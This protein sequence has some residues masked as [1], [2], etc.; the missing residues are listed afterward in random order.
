MAIGILDAEI[1]NELKPEKN[2]GVTMYPAFSLV[3][4]FSWADKAG[5]TIE[6]VEGVFYAPTSQTGQLAL[7]YVAERRDGDYEQFRQTC[8]RLASEIQA[9]AASR[10]M[11]GYFE[12][13]ISD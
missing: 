13:G 5:R 11:G 12:I 9:A 8:V 7:D 3:Q 1:S 6:W 10:E 4:I 2:G